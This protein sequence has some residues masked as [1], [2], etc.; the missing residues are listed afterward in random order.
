MGSIIRV[1]LADDH[2]VAREGLRAILEIPDI[3]W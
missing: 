1:L 2:P 3:K